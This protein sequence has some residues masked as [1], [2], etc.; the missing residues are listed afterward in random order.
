MFDLYLLHFATPE[1]RVLWQKD[2]YLEAKNGSCLYFCILVSLLASIHSLAGN[3]PRRLKYIEIK[4]FS[5]NDPFL[6]MAF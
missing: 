6:S 4:L 5:S 3:I 1:V 2:D